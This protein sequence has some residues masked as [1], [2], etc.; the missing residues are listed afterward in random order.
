MSPQGLVV[1]DKPEGP[2]SHT[3]VARARKA[4][5]TRRVGHAGNLRADKGVD[6]TGH[7][8]GGCQIGIAQG[9]PQLILLPEAIFN[10]AFNH[11]A[12]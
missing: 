12:R 10:L 8:I 4:F 6:R 11:G 3:V 5:G 1:V 7:P 2:T 9:K